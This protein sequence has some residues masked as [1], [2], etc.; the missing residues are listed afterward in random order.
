[1]SSIYAKYLDVHGT[2]IM[3]SYSNFQFI[4]ATKLN[5]PFDY[6]PSLIDSTKVPPERYQRVDTERYWVIGIGSVQ[7]IQRKSLDMLL[8]KNI[9]FNIN[10]SYYN[11]HKGV[12]IGL[13]TE[14]VAKYLHVRHRGT[15]WKVRL[16][17]HRKRGFYIIR[18]VQKRK[19]GSIRSICL[20]WLFPQYM[21]CHMNPKT[22]TK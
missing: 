12:C 2:K 8:I 5:D 21:A 14:K 15:I 16:F 6:H 17:P 10:G 4:N 19:C 7:K 13:D 1:M 22:K 20:F 11:N 3:L 9:R 18:R